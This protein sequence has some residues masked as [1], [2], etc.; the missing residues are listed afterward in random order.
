MLLRARDDVVGQHFLKLIGPDAEEVGLKLLLDVQRGLLSSS[1]RPLAA[2][3]NSW[4]LIWPLMATNS[5][6]TRRLFGPASA[7]LMSGGRALSRLVSWA[8]LGGGACLT[9]GASSSRVLPAAA[10]E[11]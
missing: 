8:P 6:C 1:S 4:F 10:A 7:A 9:N 11:E 3:G 5:A 2:A